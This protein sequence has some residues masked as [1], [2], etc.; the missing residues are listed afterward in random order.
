MKIF[1]AILLIF[2]SVAFGIDKESH[3]KFISE[4]DRK[5]SKLK[6]SPENDLKICLPLIEHY[7]KYAKGSINKPLRYTT[8]GSYTHYKIPQKIE[9]PDFHGTDPMIESGLIYRCNFLGFQTRIKDAVAGNFPD[10]NICKN[11]DSFLEAVFHG[12]VVQSLGDNHYI[13]GSRSTQVRRGHPHKYIPDPNRKILLKGGQYTSGDNGV[14][15]IVGPWE[16]VTFVNGF[17]GKAQ[18]VQHISLYEIGAVYLRFT[19]IIR[20]LTKKHGKKVACGRLN[21]KFTEYD[22]RSFKLG[23]MASNARKSKVFSEWAVTP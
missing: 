18:S 8:S 2:P 23:C 13:L 19:Q 4:L 12:Q 1:F 16:K 21:Q 10:F 14:T 20:A 7:K 17:N 11:C 15:G 22:V 9:L 6:E 5:S 3:R